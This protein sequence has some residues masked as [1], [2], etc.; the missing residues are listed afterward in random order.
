MEGCCAAGVGALLAILAS[1]GAAVGVN[2]VSC[3]RDMKGV[4]PELRRILKS[5]ALNPAEV[6]HNNHCSHAAVSAFD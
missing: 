1:I 2:G 3:R 6:G 4:C 5:Q